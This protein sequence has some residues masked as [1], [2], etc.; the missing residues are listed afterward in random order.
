MDVWAGTVVVSA[1]QIA[2]DL[3]RIIPRSTIATTMS[4]SMPKLKRRWSQSERWRIQ[5]FHC[6]M[7]SVDC[8]EVARGE[9]TTSSHPW[10]SLCSRRLPDQ[11]R[12]APTTSD[13]KDARANSDPVQ[14]AFANMLNLDKDQSE[15]QC[16]AIHWQ[17]ANLRHPK[18]MAGRGPRLAP[19]LPR[20]RPK[21]TASG[22]PEQVEM[23][24]R[25]RCEVVWQGQ[26]SVQ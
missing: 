22:C 21:G 9:R 4:I 6:R 5:R 14:V 17:T 23:L 13:T 20:M 2:L 15:A 1:C 18:L 11:R 24:V 26:T 19:T 7:F 12:D 10:P 16:L 3:L 8:D 25:C